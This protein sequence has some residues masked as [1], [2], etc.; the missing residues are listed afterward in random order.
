MLPLKKVRI[1]IFKKRL[2]ATVGF[3]F[4]AGYIDFAYSRE[5]REPQTEEI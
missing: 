4:K 3:K 5:G 1:S 2:G